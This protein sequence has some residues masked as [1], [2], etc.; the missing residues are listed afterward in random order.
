MNIAV[1]PARGGSKR[2]PRKN[3]KH[4][5][6]KPILQWPITAVMDSGLFERV[7]VSTDDEEVAEI[8]L[9]AG[10]EVPF[11]RPAELA[12]DYAAT[13]PVIRHAIQALG[14]SDSDIV[15]CIYPTA[16]FSR[17]ADLRQAM[18]LLQETEADF[19]MPVTAYSCPLARAMMIDATGRLKLSLPQHENTRTQD[20]DTFYHDV[21]QYYLGTAAAWLRDKAF[22]EQDVRALVTPRFLAHDI[23]TPDDWYF[24][25]LVFRAINEFSYDSK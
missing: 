24:A 8:A 18:A 23:D 22:Y 19:V 5:Y 1:I 3:I 20:C 17:A 4:F 16:V 11:Y 14:L 9:A 10:A 15:C 2:I 21:G 6:G 7:I 12:N 13:V 25:E